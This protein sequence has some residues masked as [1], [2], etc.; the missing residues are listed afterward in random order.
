M[1]K[2]TL[3]PWSVVQIEDDGDGSKTAILVADDELYAEDDRN[4]WPNSGFDLAH[5]YGPHQLANANLIAAAPDLLDALRG[6]LHYRGNIPDVYTAA[7][8]AAIAK[9]TQ[10]ATSTDPTR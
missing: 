6:L 8:D 5:L 3:G 1:N 9:A 2:H 7:A 4:Q 10:P